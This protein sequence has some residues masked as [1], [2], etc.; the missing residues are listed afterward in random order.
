MIMKNLYLTYL[1][2]KENSY[3]TAK[4]DLKSEFLQQFLVTI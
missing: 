2:Y 4:H 1:Y 3:L